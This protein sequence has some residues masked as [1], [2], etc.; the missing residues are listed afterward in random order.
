M[1]EKSE[2][3][4][5]TIDESDRAFEVTTSDILSAVKNAIETLYIAERAL[6]GDAVWADEKKPLLEN[7]NLLV[8]RYRTARVGLIGLISELRAREND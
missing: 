8:E 5:E 4:R 2:F 3:N 6:Y 1:S 7:K